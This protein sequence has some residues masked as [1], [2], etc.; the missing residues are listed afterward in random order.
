M[1]QQVR[2]IA[3]LNN[4][5]LISAFLGLG[6]GLG[7][8]R[9]FPRLINA[10]LPLLAVLAA[11]LAFSKGLGLMFMSF[12]DRAIALWGADGL[13]ADERFAETLF[14]IV[15]LLFVVAA[16]FAAI[17]TRIGMLFETLPPLR[18]YSVDLLGSLLGV[19]AVT[20]LAALNTSPPWWL[21]LSAAPLLLHAPTIASRVSFAVIVVAAALS[22]DGA[23]YS[24]YNRLDIVQVAKEPAV[25]YVIYANRDAHQ[26]ASDLSPGARRAAPLEER[27]SLESAAHFHQW[28]FD[29]APRKSRALIVGAGSGNDVAA[30]LRAGFASVTA[31]EID[32]VILK[33]G[34]RIHPEHP[35]A[36][37]RVTAVLNDARNYFESH[38]DERFDVVAFAL[39]DSHAMFSSMGTLRLDNYV[40]TVEGLRRGWQNVAPG[41]IMS[42]S[43]GVFHQ[44][45]VGDR[46]T[47]NLYE[48]TG[49]W[50]ATVNPKGAGEK[51]FLLTKSPGAPAVQP[52]AA[53]RTIRPS[54]DDWPFLY[55]RP[56]QFPAGYVAVLG[57]LLVMAVGG[58]RVAFGRGLYTR[59]RFDFALCLTGAAFLLLETVSISDLS[60]FFGSTWIVN[61]FVFAGILAAAYAA[62]E[63]AARF[64]PNLW[65]VGAG[66]AV[67]LAAL[68]T[69]PA[70]T[71]L[72]MPRHSGGAIALAIHVLPIAF[73][74]LLFSKL[75]ARSDDPAAALGSNLVGAIFGGVLEYLSMLTGMRLLIVVAAALYAGAVATSSARRPRQS[76]PC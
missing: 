13:R 38:R 65:L 47:R 50:P 40:Y 64:N 60:L 21:A 19:L 23:L 54:T 35:Y 68:W 22:I 17:G 74:G 37:P 57:A 34:R 33:T 67:S 44:A 49:Q 11:A 24:P 62:N 51:Q 46:L 48:A 4:I 18:A 25:S 15:A 5:I 3:Y 66:L 26:L 45:F 63:I 59:Q 9:R 70:A 14:L 56:G 36:D 16:I 43:F 61:A 1:S 7:L 10:A 20:A 72:A 31:V 2:L 55:I 8:A 58:S 30:A 6:L 52:P 39:L 42:V 69:I 76:P 27:A 75:F 28:P 41:G 29:L 12:P 32:P 53:A 73:G 71:L